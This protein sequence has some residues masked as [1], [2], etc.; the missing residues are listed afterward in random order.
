MPDSARLF[1]GTFLGEKEIAAISSFEKAN[2]NLSELWNIRARFV[3]N[4]KLHL[5]WLFLGTVEREK[6]SA[7]ET[8]LQTAIDEWKKTSGIG[9]LNIQ[10]DQLHVWPSLDSPRV[11]IIE[12]TR[13]LKLVRALNT[14]ISQHLQS[15]CQS[16]DEV[17]RFDIF[18]P[19]ITV[20]RFSPTKG[21]RIKSKREL[22]SFQ[23]PESELPISQQVSSVTLIESDLDSQSIKDHNLPKG[24]YREI[25]RIHLN[26]ARNE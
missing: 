11:L 12:A 9:V 10:F 14:S 25:K 15:F 2:P 6:I 13:D 17:E 22:E 8:C 19:H 5:T 18:R 3:P 24:S 7:V 16:K 4:E 20:C 26:G 1:V 23:I 21:P